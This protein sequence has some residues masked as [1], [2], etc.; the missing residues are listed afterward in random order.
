MSE[1]H[2]TETSGEWTPAPAERYVSVWPHTLG[3][4][5]KHPDAVAAVQ[6]NGALIVTRWGQPGAPP[7]KGYAPGAWVTFEHVGDY[8]PPVEPPRFPS[9]G[10]WSR[11]K[12]EKY[13]ADEPGPAT[14]ELPR[15]RDPVEQLDPDLLDQENGDVD[16]R[17][18]LGTLV[19]RPV[20]A[21][22]VDPDPGKDGGADPKA[23]TPAPTGEDQDDT[24]AGLARFV[25]GGS[26][27]RPRRWLRAPS[28][29]RLRGAPARSRADSP[30]PSPTHLLS[31]TQPRSRIAWWFM[32]VVSLPLLMLVLTTR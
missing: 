13:I 18:G 28:W 5:E 3:D 22:V 21:V 7:I 8:T 20:A 26:W 15:Y 10:D 1:Q 17:S 2:E 27:D 29:A 30:A 11:I 23:E 14:G 24:S 16:H 12:A 4:Y 32:A 6:P 19:P 31:L 25:F 9:V